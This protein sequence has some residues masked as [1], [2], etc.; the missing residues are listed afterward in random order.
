MR[1][2]V[3]LVLIT[4]VFCGAAFADI[5]VKEQFKREA[6][7][8]MG[9]MTPEVKRESE[10]WFGD[11]TLARVNQRRRMV[12]DTRQNR[13]ILVNLGTKTYMELP[14]PIDVQKV[15]DPQL[16]NLM[17][18]YQVVL[19]VE[20]TGKKKKV[21]DWNCSGY[22]LVNRLMQNGN[23]ATETETVH[24]VSEKMEFKWELVGR[25]TRNLSTFIV[26]D[27]ASLDQLEKI[28]G[29]PL[30]SESVRHIEGTP[31]KSVREVV[32][33]SKKEP[34]KDVYSVPA[35]FKKKET[36]T[37]DDTGLYLDR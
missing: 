8:R 28:K 34:P 5:Y 25:L 37:R 10:Y 15:R 9:N 12:L 26:E 33:I 3:L 20:E 21:K 18:M 1:K 13:I 23:I 6:F 19:K 32:E 22:K 11:G 29:F 16:S 24:W 14:L 27:E 35:G 4:M 7:Y 17:K 31:I 30:Y 36:F 2:T